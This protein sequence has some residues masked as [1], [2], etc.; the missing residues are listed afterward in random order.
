M[1]DPSSRYWLA[2][3]PS[4]SCHWIK[5]LWWQGRKLY[6]GSPHG[7]CT[8]ATQLRKSLNTHHASCGDQHWRPDMA[9]F[10]KVT[11]QQPGDRLIALDIFHNGRGSVW[12]TLNIHLSCLR[13]CF[14]LYSGLLPNC[15]LGTNRMAHSASWYSVQ[16]CPC[17]GNVALSVCSDNLL[18][19]LCPLPFWHSCFER[20]TFQRPCTVLGRYQHPS[21]LEH[22]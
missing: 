19:L 9:L 18:L 1:N 13:I 2:S 12:I 16:H 17:S 11:S 7:N 14:F 10:P 22:G 4:D 20:T 6:M 5:C 15:H 21:D 8:K 3:F